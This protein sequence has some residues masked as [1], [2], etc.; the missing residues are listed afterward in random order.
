[1]PVKQVQQRTVVATAN[2]V[3]QRT[4]VVGNGQGEVSKAEADLKRLEK[5]ARTLRGRLHA[6]L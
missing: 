5:A 1:V 6:H 4:R 2:G 3:D